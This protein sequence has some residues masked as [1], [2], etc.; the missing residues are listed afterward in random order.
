MPK[1]NVL[2]LLSLTHVIVKRLNLKYICRVVMAEWLT[3]VTKDV[4]GNRF[5]SLLI[6]STPGC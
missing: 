6:L 1:F 2:A 3:H 5:E 4:G